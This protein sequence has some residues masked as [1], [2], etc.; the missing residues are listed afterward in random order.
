MKLYKARCLENGEIW[1][2]I[3]RV[4]KEWDCSWTLV[5]QVLKIFHSETHNI[6]GIYVQFIYVSS[7]NP[8]KPSYFLYY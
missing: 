3:F 5:I 8:V 1:N 4:N 7:L 6:L 2:A